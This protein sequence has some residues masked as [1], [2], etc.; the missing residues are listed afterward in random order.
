MSLRFAN[1]LYLYRKPMPNH[2]LHR[3]CEDTLV[4]RSLL[5]LLDIL[6]IFVEHVTAG[7]RFLDAQSNIRR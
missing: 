3:P 7:E 4:P 1:K 6:E 2:L 5:I